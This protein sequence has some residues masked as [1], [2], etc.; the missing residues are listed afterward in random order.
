MKTAVALLS[1]ICAFAFAGPELSYHGSSPEWLFSGGSSK[2]TF[3]H[4]EDF[5]PGA[6]EFTIEWAEVW[7]YSLTAPAYVEIW[8]GAGSG[9]SELLAR[10]ELTESRVWFNPPVVTGADFWCVVNSTEPQS[11]LADGEPDGHSF[12]S[13]DFLVWEPFDLGEFFISVGNDNESL[14]R[15]SWGMIK[16]CFQ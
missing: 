10:E 2:G 5:I 11:I 13:E 15:V 6:S 3:F 7:L 12:F 4:L 16:N 1:A 14:G 8:N 9:P